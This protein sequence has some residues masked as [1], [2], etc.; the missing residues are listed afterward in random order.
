MLRKW[1]GSAEQSCGPFNS[2]TLSNVPSPQSL[3]LRRRSAGCFQGSSEVPISVSYESSEHDRHRT[4]K[5]LTGRGPGGSVEMGGLLR[6]SSVNNPI[7]VVNAS[8]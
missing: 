4:E 5:Q 3:E 2:K 6:C 8:A 7:S 1:I